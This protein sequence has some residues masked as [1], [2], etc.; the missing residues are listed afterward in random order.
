M[1]ASATKILDYLKNLNYKAFAELEAKVNELRASVNKN[2]DEQNR[3]A[4][5]SFDDGE[6]DARQR[7]LRYLSENVK[8][9]ESL[10][11]SRN[12]LAGLAK[13]VLVDYKFRKATSVSSPLISETAY[14]LREEAQY[15][16]KRAKKLE[17]LEKDI[18]KL[19]E[20]SNSYTLIWRFA[21][22]LSETRIGKF[23][24]IRTVEGIANKG[25]NLVA[26][27][28]SDE[29]SLLM[30]KGYSKNIPVSLD[31]VSYRLMT[32]GE[33]YYLSKTIG[34]AVNKARWMV[35]DPY[36]ALISLL[37]K[38]D[39]EGYGSRELRPDEISKAYMDEI[40]KAYR[41]KKRN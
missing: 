32:L 30:S 6:E 16:K 9:P 24:R 2:L 10:D 7:L 21:T 37:R 31:D 8:K 40:R 29:Q 12:M 14:E 18:E 11:E 13:N 17:K 15:L 35:F 34:L 5:H 19:F 1:V 26:S 25:E 28:I 4:E 27:I 23:L 20:R 36:E 33:H 39:K 38:E 22:W 3:I 41:N